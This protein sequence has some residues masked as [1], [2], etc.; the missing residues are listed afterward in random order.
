MK[1][2]LLIFTL[3][4]LSIP[5]LA[6]SSAGQC[7]IL[8]DQDSGRILYA[9]NVNTVRSVASI[10]KIMTAILAIESNKL[11]SIVEIGEE[12]NGAYG[13]GIYIKVGEQMSLRDLV[14][15]LMLR[16]G[17]D[18]ALA[19]A[20]YV[21]G[22]VEKFVEMMNVK[23]K[24]IGM[25]NTIFNNPSGLDNDKKGNYSTAYDM[26][27]LTRYA[28]QN[29]E[30]Q[31]IVSTKK[32]TVKTN[33]NTY[34]WINK[35]K[36]LTIYKYTTGGKTGFTEIAKRTLVSTASKDNF[37]LIVVT[38]NNGNDFNEHVELYKEAFE[39]YKRYQILK[40]GVIN[41]LNEKHYKDYN[42]YINNNFYYPLTPEEK[43]NIYLKIE[44]EK[45]R[46]YKKGNEVGKVMVMVGDKKIHED[47]IYLGELK[48]KNNSNIFKKIIGW[49]RNLW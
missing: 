11:D 28:M 2:I 47:I 39:V 42:L 31:K 24:E 5:V 40:K 35:N 19:I 12:I 49:V 16:S 41:V 46:S 13:S 29:K 26:A 33:M 18:A 10:S 38:L 7:T 36:L 37:N 27:V 1:K 20:H 17:N 3:I 6:F 15:G 45:K 34:V 32:H 43:D 22:S 9:K 14:Y 23:A 8:M 21:G 4:I 44:M 25:K 30:Y 48:V